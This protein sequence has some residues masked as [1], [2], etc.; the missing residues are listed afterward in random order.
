MASFG[1]IAMGLGIGR[2]ASPHDRGRVGRA[3]VL[4]SVLSMLPDIDY[5]WS[6]RH[7]PFF[8]HQSFHGQHTHSIVFSIAVAAVVALLFG[9]RLYGRTRTFLLA[10]MA[11]GSH[12]L[13]D[14]L[15]ME[16]TNALWVLWPL[17]QSG[18]RLPDAW[19]FMRAAPYST[20]G[21]GSLILEEAAMTLPILVWALWPRGRNKDRA[22]PA[23]QQIEVRHRAG[24]LA[25]VVLFVLSIPFVTA[26]ARHGVSYLGSAW[27]QT[28]GE[29]AHGTTI[30]A[31]SLAP[32]G[33]GFR[34]YS[35]VG[36]AMG[37]QYTT[38][39]VEKDLRQAAAKNAR[40][41]PFYFAETGWRSGGLF[42][43][44]RTHQNGTSVDLLMPL[45]KGYRPARWLWLQFG[46]GVDYGHGRNRNGK[47]WQHS[48]AH[49][50]DF[51]R[52]K[53]FLKTLCR[54]KR[55][56]YVY[57]HRRHKRHLSGSGCRLKN[58]FPNLKQTDFDPHDDHVHIQFRRKE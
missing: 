7:S 40:H 29:S 50:I 13:L 5:L 43:P 33:P 2:L 24:R 6:H 19:T 47:R 1:H 21:L 51:N 45:K 32:W 20:T 46:Y 26:W 15:C 4:F 39:D 49:Q 35:I 58:A 38:P 18:L 36:A 14:L 22:S 25:L 41:G 55:V 56:A 30:G 54:T 3:M 48:N 23:Q 52:L 37:R 42:L 57:V 34:S 9:G 16:R 11:V 17:Q 44:H 12:V 27:A 31:R 8:V 28:F 10:F 53:A